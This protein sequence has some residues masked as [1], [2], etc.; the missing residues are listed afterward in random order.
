[1]AGLQSVSAGLYCAVSAGGLS[2]HCRLAAAAMAVVLRPEPAPELHE[3]RT[4]AAGKRGQ[5]KRHRERMVLWF[6]HPAMTHGS[7]KLAIVSGTN[8]ECDRAEAGQFANMSRLQWCTLSL[9]GNC[10]TQD[11][12][13]RHHSTEFLV[14]AVYRLSHKLAITWPITLN[15]S[16]VT[17][18][19]INYCRFA[20]LKVI[21]C[22]CISGRIQNT[23]S[24][25]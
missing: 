19:F 24:G 13:A 4:D 20:V 10:D 6:K 5:T 8:P 9:K 21:S 11:R 1:M 15:P 7:D 3:R 22:P 12:D 18:C 14:G 17:I 16:V 23:T 25:L 2:R